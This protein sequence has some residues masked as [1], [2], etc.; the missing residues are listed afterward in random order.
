MQS[1]RYLCSKS[2]V[3]RSFVSAAIQ[4]LH[5]FIAM[6]MGFLSGASKYCQKSGSWRIL[7]HVWSYQ[8]C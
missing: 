4:F 8:L 7:S 1:L 6:C 3:T 5:F 2:I